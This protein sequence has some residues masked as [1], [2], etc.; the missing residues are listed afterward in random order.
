M[1]GGGGGGGADKVILAVNV[2]Q[3]GPYGAP[4]RSIHAQWGTVP[5]FLWKHIATCDV[6]SGVQIQ[7]VGLEM[8]WLIV[9]A[10]NVKRWSRKLDLLIKVKFG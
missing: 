6:I 3:R 8:C 10:V 2:F 4:L 9:L 7:A 1:G 5:E